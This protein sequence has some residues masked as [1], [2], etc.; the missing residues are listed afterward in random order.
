M[1]SDLWSNSLINGIFPAASER[2]TCSHVFSIQ[3]NIFTLVPDVSSPVEN[4]SCSESTRCCV[5]NVILFSWFQ[6]VLDIWVMVMVKT[7]DMA[8]GGGRCLSRF[9]GPHLKLG[10]R[11]MKRF[12]HSWNLP[13]CHWPVHKDMFSCLLHTKLSMYGVSTY[14]CTHTW[15]WTMHILLQ[16]SNGMVA[17]LFTWL[18]D[19]IPSARGYNSSEWCENSKCTQ[20]VK[21]MIHLHECVMSRKYTHIDVWCMQILWL[22]NP[23]LCENCCEINI[24]SVNLF[25]NDH[26]T[27]YIAHP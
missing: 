22:T 9:W 4:L 15:I 16:D 7:L 19:Y 2:E 12:T 27:S 13:W 18:Y 21:I 25:L 10:S 20:T 6:C 17:L 8:V 26:N 23:V 11:L 5:Q 24:E 1:G 3:N 14:C